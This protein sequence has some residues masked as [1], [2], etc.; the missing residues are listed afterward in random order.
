MQRL[1]K[2]KEKAF[3]ACL[4][5]DWLNT[6]ANWLNGMKLIGGEV[7]HTPDGIILNPFMLSHGSVSDYSFRVESNGDNTATMTPGDV[8][9]GPNT[10]VTWAAFTTPSTT[11]TLTDGAAEWYA[12]LI[13]DVREDA[14]A[15]EWGQGGSLP[16]LSSED[17][18]TKMLVPLVKITADG[19]TPAVITGVKNLQCGDV[20]IPRL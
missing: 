3:L 9:L 8:R 5:A 7:I 4:K 16:S 17:L 13:V 1:T 11:L 15:V 20:L 2:F 6:A 10:L 12:W 14:E 18:K 19:A